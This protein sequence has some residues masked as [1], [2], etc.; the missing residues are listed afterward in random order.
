[1][2]RNQRAFLTTGVSRPLRKRAGGAGCWELGRGRARGCAVLAAGTSSSGRQMERGISLWSDRGHRDSLAAR[3][4]RATAP[5]SSSSSSSS[6]VEQR[7]D[8]LPSACSP[9]RRPA[10]QRR[11]VR[12]AC[13]LSLLTGLP[14]DKDYRWRP[15]HTTHDTRHTRVP[16]CNASACP[17]PRP[18][19]STMQAPPP[20][21]KP[22]QLGFTMPEPARQACFKPARAL[23]A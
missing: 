2:G 19:A 7:R 5:S 21:P 8:N 20:L 15:A 18:A 12:I 6:T 10:K 23:A 1:L 4:D 14:P 22:S 16:K 13:A 9:L 3:Q 11:R 17:L